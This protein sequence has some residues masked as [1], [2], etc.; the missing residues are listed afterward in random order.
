MDG[1]VSG[2]IPDI[3]SFTEAVVNAT[4]TEVFNILSEQEAMPGINADALAAYCVLQVAK[5]AF[6]DFAEEHKEAFEEALK[7]ENS[8][9]EVM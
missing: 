7:I 4:F 9:V 2:S 8:N 6:N 1:Q 5:N 3:L